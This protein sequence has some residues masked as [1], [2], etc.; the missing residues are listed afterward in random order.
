MTVCDSRRAMPG[1]ARG[2]EGISGCGTGISR[3]RSKGCYDNELSSD[4]VRAA[5]SDGGGL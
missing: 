1:V 3:S 2:S 4:T 5:G